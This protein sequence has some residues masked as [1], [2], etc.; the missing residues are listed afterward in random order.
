[1]EEFFIR[2]FKGV[3]N[4]MKVNATEAILKTDNGSFSD[5]LLSTFFSL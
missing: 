1:M 4:G 3:S 5:S 2:Y